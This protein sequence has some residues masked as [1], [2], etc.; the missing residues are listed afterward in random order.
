[1][2]KIYVESHEV[3]YKY[4]YMALGIFVIFGSFFWSLNVWDDVFFD[5]S[6]WL[7]RKNL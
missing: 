7:T 6:N 3:K 4:L 5:R 1:M 2:K